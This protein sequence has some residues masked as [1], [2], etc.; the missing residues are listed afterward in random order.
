MPE[1]FL[2]V[3]L[4]TILKVIFCTTA[5]WTS[6]FYGCQKAKRKLETVPLESFLYHLRGPFLPPKSGTV[7]NS[8]GGTVL[9][10][11]LALCLPIFGTAWGIFGEKRDTEHQLEARWAHR[12][13][14]FKLSKIWV[15]HST[16]EHVFV[17]SYFFLFSRFSCHIL[18][19]Y[20]SIN[21]TNKKQNKK[22][23]KTT[24]KNGKRQGKKEM[25]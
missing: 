23:T 4:C 16:T 22:K 11:Y 6:H 24:R 3:L 18:S 1:S 12:W 9:N 5:F 8:Q 10:F 21:P 14:S 2:S 19:C 15:L 13:Y 17:L 25:K 20:V 7:S